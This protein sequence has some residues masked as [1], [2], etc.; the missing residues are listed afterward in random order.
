[1]LRHCIA[2]GGG[3]R[4]QG[5]AAG[6]EQ[7]PHTVHPCSWDVVNH[8]NTLHFKARKRGSVVAITLDADAKLEEKFELILTD[9]M[10]YYFMNESITRNAPL[11]TE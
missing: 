11:E 10:R 8:P 9:Y 6:R 4:P 7:E 3:S 2:A 5:R 1:V